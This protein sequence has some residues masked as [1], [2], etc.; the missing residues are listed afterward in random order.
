MAAFTIT[1]RDETLKTEIGDAFAASYANPDSLTDEELVVLHVS[2]FIRGVL[3][4][5]R[6]K[7]AVEPAESG[8]TK[9]STLE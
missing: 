4:D 2:N 3:N 6:V 8:V 1:V 7:Q 5:Y 9:E